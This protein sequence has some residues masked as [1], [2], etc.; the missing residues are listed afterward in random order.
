MLLLIPLIIYSRNHLLE[1]TV[2]MSESVNH[3]EQNA[4]CPCYVMC[5]QA[6]VIDC[7]SVL[8]VQQVIVLFP[9]FTH[10]RD[11]LVDVINVRR[12]LHF[13]D[14]VLTEKFPELLLFLVLKRFIDRIAMINL[15]FKWIHVVL[16]L[17][18]MSESN[19]LVS[20][21]SIVFSAIRADGVVRVTL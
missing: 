9:L 11:E 21:I 15:C 10:I 19:S 14:L 1:A 16:L 6:V 3:T 17:L 18:C 2:F 5:D 12:S 13:V 7:I 20:P 4:D 8:E